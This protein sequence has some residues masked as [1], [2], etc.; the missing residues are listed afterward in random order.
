MV[1]VTLLLAY[2]A[3]GASSGKDFITRYAMLASVLLVWIYAIGYVLYIGVYLILYTIHGSSVVDQFRMY[4]PA[5][6]VFSA[7][8]A[9]VFLLSLQHFMAQVSRAT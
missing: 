2:K 9:L 5:Q 7:I 4:G 8:T 6:L 1:L 3:N